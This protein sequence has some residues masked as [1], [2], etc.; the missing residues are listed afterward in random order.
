M[1]DRPNK[2]SALAATPQQPLPQAT[3]NINDGLVKA[4][5]PTG[6][7]VEVLLYGATVTSWKD[8]NGQEKLWLSDKAV[9]DGTKAVRGGIPLVFP[10]SILCHNNPP[11]PFSLLRS[12]CPFLPPVVPGHTQKFLTPSARRPHCF[13]LRLSQITGLRHRPRS[14]RHLQTSPARLCAL[15]AVGV[16]GQEHQRVG[17]QLRLGR[18]VR[19]ARLWT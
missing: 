8:A 5:L 4:S 2:P 6:E 14:R 15:V 17:Q 13:P 10:V 18:P 7:T 9:L 1:V 11:P 19:Q 3:V 16:P 12:L